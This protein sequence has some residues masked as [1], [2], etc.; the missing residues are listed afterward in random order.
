MPSITAASAA[1]ANAG[2]PLNLDWASLAD[3]AA[4]LAIYMGRAGAFDVAAKLIGH[5][6]SRET[7][8]SL[9]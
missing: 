9:L 8:C 1:V 2:E 6:L 4:T 3:P 7:P 5:G